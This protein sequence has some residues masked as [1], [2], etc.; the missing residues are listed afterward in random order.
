MS[1]F[2]TERDRLPTQDGRNQNRT[3]QFVKNPEAVFHSPIVLPIGTTREKAAVVVCPA[4]HA[5]FIP[6][7]LL[8]YPW[9]VAPPFAKKSAGCLGT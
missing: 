1:V 4:S 3:A 9:V 7:R 6:F 8:L 5:F 2:C